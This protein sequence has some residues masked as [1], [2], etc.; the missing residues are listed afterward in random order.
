ML[1]IK[2]KPQIVTCDGSW[3][4]K[5]YGAIFVEKEEDI[6][7]LFKL[8]CDQDDYWEDYKELI[9]VAPKEVNSKSDLYKYCQW[10]GKTDIYDVKALKEKIP[11]IIYQ[12]SDNNDY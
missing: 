6:D 8:L 11:F 3:E 2:I 5:M 9:H 7:P 1:E 10:C 4:S 12:Y